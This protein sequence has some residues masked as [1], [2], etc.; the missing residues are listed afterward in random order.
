[1]LG[2]SEAW[3]V[4]SAGAPSFS[5]EFPF[6]VVE[7]PRFIRGYGAPL[8]RAPANYQLIEP[9]VIPPALAGQIPPQQAV[10]AVA[11][12]RTA[13]LLDPDGESLAKCLAEIDNPPAPRL[14]AE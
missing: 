2:A 6:E 10:D 7:S 11:S 5:L 13:A 12:A 14:A 9:H 3:R 1:A 8:K 4:L